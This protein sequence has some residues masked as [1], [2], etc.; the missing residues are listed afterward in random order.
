MIFSNDHLVSLTLSAAVHLVGL[1]L[2]GDAARRP[3]DAPADAVPELLIASV[4][5][6]LSETEPAAPGA[7][8]APAQ[9]EAPPLAM[10]EPEPELPQQMPEKQDFADVLPDLPLPPPEPDPEPQPAPVPDPPPAPRPPPPAPVPP[11]PPA[12]PPAPAEPAPPTPGPSVE[13]S[14]AAG[15]GGAA[16]HVDAR[17]SLDRPIRP[18]YPLG[19]RRRG[20]EGTVVLDVKVAAD[21]RAAGVTLVRSSG[22]PELDRSAERAAAQARFNPATRGGRPVESAARL[23]LV[24]RLRDL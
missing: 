11:R 24:F 8:A 17:P 4:Q 20:E 12:A 18:V 22:F 3:L 21:G 2:L 23:T 14:E 5:L 19:A 7:V 13:S 10:P 6:T 16:G 9:P 15:D 1:L